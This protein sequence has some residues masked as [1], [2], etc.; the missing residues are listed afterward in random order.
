MKTATNL[1]TA[2]I[3]TVKKAKKLN[4][5]L[6]EAFRELAP[7]MHKTACY[8][9]SRWYRITSLLNN[10]EDTKEAKRN[11]CFLSLTTDH[12]AINRGIN[13]IANNKTI[14]SEQYKRIL[15]IIYGEE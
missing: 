6:R 15:N 7:R 5:P 11:V 14:T 4:K 13:S 9:E 3:A 1:D 10:V 12:V 8:L 2:I